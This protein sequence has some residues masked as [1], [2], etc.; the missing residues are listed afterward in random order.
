[1]KKIIHF[2]KRCEPKHEVEE[3]GGALQPPKQ[4]RYEKVATAN[5]DKLKKLLKDLQIEAS[6]GSVKA[7]N[8][9]FTL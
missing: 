6:G 1:M 3:V 4:A 8:K 9:T 5:T 7:K 2:R